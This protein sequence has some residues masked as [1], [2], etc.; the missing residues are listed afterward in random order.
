MRSFL[1]ACLVFGL[2][3]A[4]CA[5]GGDAIVGGAASAH[6]Y[7]LYGNDGTYRGRIESGRIYGADGTYRGR[8]ES[9]AIYGGDG[10]R[11]DS[12]R[13]TS[14]SAAQPGPSGQQQGR[15]TPAMGR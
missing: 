5:Q 10:T 1:A 11:Q 8:I 13:L 4:A 3:G 9:G 15:I 14:R 6:G 12:L 2:A 7:R